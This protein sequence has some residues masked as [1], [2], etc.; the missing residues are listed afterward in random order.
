MESEDVSCVLDV[1]CFI[2]EGVS[3]GQHIEDQGVQKEGMFWKG[4]KRSAN[5]CV[6]I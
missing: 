2:S 5:R 3:I 4:A 6:R 1:G